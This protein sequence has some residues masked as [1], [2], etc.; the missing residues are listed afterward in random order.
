MKRLLK[1]NINRP[2]D[3]CILSKFLFHFGA[4]YFASFQK[5]YEE[6]L[7]I[8]YTYEKLFFPQNIKLFP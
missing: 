2:V 8:D 1:E 3:K 4:F 5:D 7:D 6:I